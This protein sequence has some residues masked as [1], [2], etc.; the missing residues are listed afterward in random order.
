MS[1]PPQVL[2]ALEKPTQTAIA[3]V[4]PQDM[5][6]IINGP[7]LGS[8][9]GAQLIGM[10]GAPSKTQL[11]EAIIALLMDKSM[12]G[13]AIDAKIAEALKKAPSSGTSGGINASSV[14]SKISKALDGV[15]AKI[16]TALEGVDSKIS[17][18]VEGHLT[19]ANVGKMR[20]APASG[21]GRRR[22]RRGKRSGSKRR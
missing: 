2:N 12:L 16:K 4:P 20:L 15:D 17:K 22:T 18:A 1:L 8:I 11:K 9:P 3:K 5:G 6:M 7:L 21:G 13:A 14:D 19:A 10:P